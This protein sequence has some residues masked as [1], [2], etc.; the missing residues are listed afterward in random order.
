M[1]T[2]QTLQRLTDCLGSAHSAVRN[3]PNTYPCKTK[4]IYEKKIKPSEGGPTD[5]VAVIDRINAS[6]L[7]QTGCL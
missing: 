5:Q 2:S 6:P 4:L 7:H 3:H 1:K